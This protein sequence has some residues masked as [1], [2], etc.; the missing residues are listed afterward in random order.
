M[1]AL[2]EKLKRYG[3][4]IQRFFVKAEIP[5]TLIGLTVLAMAIRV[6]LFDGESGDYKQFLLGRKRWL[7]LRY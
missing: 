2:K 5:L 7:F 6:M 3:L 4:A 1:Q